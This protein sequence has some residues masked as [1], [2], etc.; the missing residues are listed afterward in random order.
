MF[1]SVVVVDIE[2]TGLSVKEHVICEIGACAVEKVGGCW[3][4]GESFCMRIR[5]SQQEIAAA[6]AD[7]LAINGFTPELNEKGAD[8]QEVC[9]HFD[10]WLHGVRPQLLVAHNAR[11]DRSFCIA[12][13]LVH[14]SVPWV[15]TMTAFANW[16]KKT[17][18][19]GSRKLA[20]LAKFA[21][22]EAVTYHTALG[23]V[24]ACVGGLIFLINQ[25]GEQEVFSCTSL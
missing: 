16:R 6:R 15:C 17:G 1:T 9:R 21:S 2:S 7:A 14:E 18:N 19:T 8:R 22:S 23:D 25:L 3:Q 20:E 24:N 4:K 11:F 12:G 5:L 10:E 13:G